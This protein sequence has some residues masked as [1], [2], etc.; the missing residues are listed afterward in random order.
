MDQ[1]ND[2][3]KSFHDAVESF[4]A[5][6]ELIDDKLWSQPATD[7]W[8]V[9]EL[10]SHTA[11]G[12]AII[13]DY[14]DVDLGPNPR[15][16]IDGAVTYFRLALSLEGVHSGIKDRAVQASERFRDA[17]LATAREVAALVA[18]RVERTVDDQPM[19]V[20]VETMRFIDYLRTRIVELV[21]HTFDLQ[22]ACGL[23]LRAPTSGLAVVE[24]IL[25]ALADRADPSALVLALSGRASNLVCNVLG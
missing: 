13:I 23:P 11:R 19:K 18:E 22:L 25:L 1:P 8:S 7:Q 16:T 24:E 10:F 12:M 2:I 9:L 6:G 3:R 20:F 21:L 5:T 4:L 17:P 14:L 15:V